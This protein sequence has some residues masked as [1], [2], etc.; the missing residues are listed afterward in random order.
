MKEENKTKIGITFLGLFFG[1]VGYFT[2]WAFPPEFI[3]YNFLGDCKFYEISAGGSR[4][5][6]PNNGSVLIENITG[7]QVYAYVFTHII[8]EQ[9][10]NVREKRT[11]ILELFG[12]NDV[13]PGAPFL[14]LPSNNEFA[15]KAN[16]VFPLKIPEGHTLKLFTPHTKNIEFNVINYGFFKDNSNASFKGCT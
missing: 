14:I 3:S 16:Q 2:G 15:I 7:N 12:N 10:N 6:H 1:G 13:D 11:T 5:I 8:E 4:D 9:T